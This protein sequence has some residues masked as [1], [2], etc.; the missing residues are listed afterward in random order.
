[1]FDAYFNPCKYVS[2]PL[3]KSCYSNMDNH[4]ESPFGIPMEEWPSG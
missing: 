4:T 3:N 2:L 1:M